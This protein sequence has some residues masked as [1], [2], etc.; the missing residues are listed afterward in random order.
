M[1]NYKERIVPYGGIDAEGISDSIHTR[2]LV[3]MFSRM[4]SMQSDAR[5]AVPRTVPALRK[6]TS[7]D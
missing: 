7:D 4:Q 6:L 3:C 5:S 1:Y 2:H